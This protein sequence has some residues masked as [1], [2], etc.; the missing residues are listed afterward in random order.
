MSTVDDEILALTDAVNTAIAAASG[1]WRGAFSSLTAYATLDIVSYNG[2][3]YMATT[4]IVAGA[5]T[6]NAVA[7]DRSARLD[8]R[9]WRHGARWSDWFHGIHRTHGPPGTDRSHWTNWPYGT[10]RVAHC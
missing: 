2:S 9:D 10:R 6:D 7:T 1:R 3:S 5:A 8:R 4:P